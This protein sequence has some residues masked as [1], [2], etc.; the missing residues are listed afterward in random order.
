MRR[1][2]FHL[3]G[4]EAGEISVV[5]PEAQHLSRVLR[6]RPGDQ[7]LAF[8]GEGLEARGEVSAVDDA[9]VT[10]NLQEP[11]PSEV[12][13][14]L[15]VTVAVALLKGDKLSDVVR[16]CTELGAVRFQPL[17]TKQADVPQLSANKLARLQRVARE[18]AKQSGRSVVPEVAPAI[19][20]EELQWQGVAVLAHLRASEPLAGALTPLP[21]GTE[22][23][24]IT[25]PEGGFAAEEAQ[26]LVDRGATPVYLG[27]RI[28]RAETA[29]IALLSAI[30]LPE[31]R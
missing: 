13:S 20:L 9:S 26:S 27:K 18:A 6:V 15:Q 30:L 29:P 5:G 3:R 22:L 24:L 16:R 8:D 25:G 14:D 21:E 23:T 31:A 12:E 11:Q 4:L 2:R 7:V 1:H 28:L 17:P 19:P 10:V